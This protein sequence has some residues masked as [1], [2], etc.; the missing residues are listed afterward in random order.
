MEA[1]GRAVVIETLGDRFAENF[2]VLP[3]S[4][5][6]GGILL[7]VDEDFYRLECTELGIHSVTALIRAASGHVQWHITVVYG[8]QEDNDKLMFLAELRWMKQVVSDNWLLIGDFNL[9]LHAADKS[10]TNL[11]RRLMGAFRDVVQDLD[12]IEL[13]LR[14]RKFTWSND[15][16]QTR[17]DHTFC[18]AAWDLMMPSAVL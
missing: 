3:A 18:S 7:A 13:N 5:T 17:I 4:G 15:R 11:N 1:I 2:V 10:N 9:I 12:L 6:R 14:G 16:T 8:P